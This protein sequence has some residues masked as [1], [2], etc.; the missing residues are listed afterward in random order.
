MIQATTIIIGAGQCGLAASAALEARGIDNIVLERGQIANSW[1]TERWDSLRMLTPNWMNTVNG[2]RYVGTDPDGFMT[3]AELLSEF[4][5]AAQNLSGSIWTDTEVTRLSQDTEGFKAETTSGTFRS[6][7]VILAN[8]AFAKPH[9]PTYAVEIPDRIAQFNT[10]T[11]KRADDIPKGRV[12][13]IGASASGAQIANELAKAGRSVTLSAGRHFRL[14]RSYRGRDILY[15]LTETGMLDR[16]YTSFENLQAVR[17]EPSFQLVAGEQLDINTLQRDG[18]QIVG[19]VAGIQD[20]LIELDN[21]R[22]KDCS[23]SDSD[24]FALLAEIDRFIEET[25]HD[26]LA[27]SPTAPDPI[28]FSSPSLGV[29]DLNTGEFG[30]VIWASGLKPDYSW[31]DLPVFDEHGT[32]VHDGGY[33]LPGLYALGLPSMIRPSSTF[34]G[35]AMKDANEIADHLLRQTSGLRGV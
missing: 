35:G 33:V 22:E 7:N 34:I 32:L 28:Q 24:L 8:G 18:V 10:Q 17:H 31:L 30:T 4:D 25:D 12:L 11:Y 5:S 9:I 1:R 16:H 6:Q 14:P 27:I 19:R 3:V 2:E 20:G 21:N 29:F 26:C 15:W 13:V 23:T